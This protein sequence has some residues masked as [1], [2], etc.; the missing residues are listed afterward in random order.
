MDCGGPRAPA[1]RLSHTPTLS[2]QP[3]A[4][5][6]APGSAPCAS[7]GITAGTREL[8]YKAVFDAGFFSAE[9]AR[10]VGSVSVG[11]L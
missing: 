9:L 3:G 10:L 5:R 8:S 11:M 1:I 4:S 6:L 7:F 2:E